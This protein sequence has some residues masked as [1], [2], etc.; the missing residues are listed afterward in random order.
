METAMIAEK[1]SVQKIIEQNPAR[2][3]VHSRGGNAFEFFAL[4]TWLDANQHVEI[5]VEGLCCGG[6]ILLPAAARRSTAAPSALFGFMGHK[7]IASGSASDLKNHMRTLKML[8][9]QFVGI[10]TRRCPASP[11]QVRQWMSSNTWMSAKQAFAEGLI[12]EIL[13]G[14]L[15]NEAPEW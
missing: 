12:D 3:T 10:V 6:A 9:D 4:A 1:V 5:H 8:D 15:D 7:M 2:I 14:S 13:A 11:S